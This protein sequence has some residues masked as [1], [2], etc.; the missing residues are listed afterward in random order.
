M[1]MEN[2]N[3][4]IRQFSPKEKDFST[5]T[6]SEIIDVQNN[7]TIDQEKVWVLKHLQRFFMVRF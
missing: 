3:G 2:T 4:L 5:I 1:V 7:L 6:R